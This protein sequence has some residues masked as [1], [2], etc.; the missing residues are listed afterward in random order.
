MGFKGSKVQTFSSRPTGKSGTYVKTRVP[1]FVFSAPVVH[2]SSPRNGAVQFPC[3]LVLS[4]RGH[5][6]PSDMPLY[7]SIL[8]TAISLRHA[9]C[10]RHRIEKNPSRSELKRNF[11]NFHSKCKALGCL[12][13]IRLSTDAGDLRAHEDVYP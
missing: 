1:F 12:L 11:V 2:P 10:P 6:L 5:F 7:R 9:R 8:G 3:R 4:G 13:L